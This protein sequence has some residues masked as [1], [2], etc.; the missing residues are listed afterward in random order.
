MATNG[1]EKYPP[2]RTQLHNCQGGLLARPLI[3]QEPGEGS[4]RPPQKSLRR[5]PRFQARHH[6]RSQRETPEETSLTLSPPVTPPPPFLAH[7]CRGPPQSLGQHGPSPEF[8]FGMSPNCPFLAQAHPGPREPLHAHVCGCRCAH[9]RSIPLRLPA[10]QLRGEHTPATRPSVGG[11]TRRGDSSGPGS[12]LKTSG[13]RIPGS[14]YP[15]CGLGWVG[16]GCRAPAPGGAHSLGPTD[17]LGLKAGHGRRKARAG[18][19]EVWG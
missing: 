4:G 5:C 13:H 8:E 14:Q 2:L 15:E 10:L 11:Q 9:P 6:P 18:S 12:N 3:H 7:P 1:S 19:S 17:S 16:G